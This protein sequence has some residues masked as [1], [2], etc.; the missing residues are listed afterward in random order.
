MKKNMLSTLRVWT[1]HTLPVVPPTRLTAMTCATALGDAQTCAMSPGMP[2]A[3]AHVASSSL[4]TTTA[5]THDL[6]LSPYTHA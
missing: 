4:G 6:K 2:F 1:C 3:A 5:T